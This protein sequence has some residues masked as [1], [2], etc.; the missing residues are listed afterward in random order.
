M[1]KQLRPAQAQGGRAL[2]GRRGLA[3]SSLRHAP[4]A[5]MPAGATAAPEASTSTSHSAHDGHAAQ[6]HGPAFKA[7][8]DFKSMKENL[9][10]YV[11]NTRNRLSNADP[12][13]A[14]ELYE[15][16]VKLK[17]DADQ[18]RAERNENA[19]SMKVGRSRSRVS[20]R[21]LMITMLPLGR[22]EERRVEGSGRKRKRVAQRCGRTHKCLPCGANTAI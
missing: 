14:V 1:Q 5:P 9:D 17:A 2:A 11:T 20:I 3:P 6:H 22:R 10:L 21:P 19:N 16:F 15:Q 13:K 12:K 18:L 7:A 8:L 4:R